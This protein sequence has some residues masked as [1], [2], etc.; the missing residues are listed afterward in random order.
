MRSCA[1]DRNDGL[2]EVYVV[3]CGS[4]SDYSIVSVYADRAAADQRVAGENARGYREEHRV[5]VYRLNAPPAF[6]GVVWKSVWWA[7]PVGL[8]PTA[9]PAH[10]YEAWYEGDDPG[11]ATATEGEDYAYEGHPVKARY[12]SVVGHSKEH[13]EKSANDRRQRVRA[14]LMGIA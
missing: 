9:P 6:A 5:E 4:Y 14:E 7:L 3:T 1:V 10:A 8:S 11:T 2:G 12:V 13:V